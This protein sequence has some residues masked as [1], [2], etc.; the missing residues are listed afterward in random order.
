MFTTALL[1]ASTAAVAQDNANE[2]WLEKIAGSYAL[3]AFEK[4]GEPVPADIKNKFE[5]ITI[6][7]NK[8]TVTFKEDAK[9]EVT[10][11]TI[12][13]DAS[14]DP[15]SIDFKPGIASQKND[16]VPGIVEVTEDAVRLCWADGPGAKR[17]VAFNSTKQ[18]KN[19][20]LTLK[21]IKE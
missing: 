15:V 9:A 17:P 12:S 8:L 20:L 2:K 7:G 18:N 4:G 13:V 21:K 19:F 6:K 14:K 1:L 11:T 3:S 10:T 5:S 16:A